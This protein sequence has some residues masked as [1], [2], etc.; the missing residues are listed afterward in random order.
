M[1]D[2]V[3][4]EGKALPDRVPIL[5]FGDVGTDPVVIPVQRQRGGE[6]QPHHRI[7]SEGTGSRPRQEFRRSRVGAQPRY[8]DCGAVR[9]ALR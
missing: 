3:P 9:R 4:G 5:S 1:V 7:A 2:M 6:K 8:V